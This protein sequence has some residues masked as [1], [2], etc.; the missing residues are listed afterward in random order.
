MGD[1]DPRNRYASIKEEY[2]SA[3][4][5]SQDGNEGKTGDDDSSGSDSQSSQDS[6]DGGDEKEGMEQS[7]HSGSIKRDRASVQAY[8]PDDEKDELE[9]TLRKIKALCNLAGEDEPLKNDFYAAALRH[10]YTD[11]ESI[12]VYLKLEEAYDEYGEVIS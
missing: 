12:A 7:A 5:E 8:I 1:E 6:I 11:I 4:P 10:G 2:E 9:S 3:S